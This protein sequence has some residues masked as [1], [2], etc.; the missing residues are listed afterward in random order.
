MLDAFEEQGTV[1][2]VIDN[3]KLPSERL[4]TGISQPTS[5]CL[6]LARTETLRVLS[7]P[8]L[9]G[10]GTRRTSLTS[11]LRNRLAVDNG[12]SSSTLGPAHS[13]SVVDRVEYL[14][15]GLPYRLGII[16]IQHL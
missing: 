9:T 10:D 12:H 11:T 8:T 15:E 6:V 1:F 14:H 13:G 7:S 16:Q 3:T 2:R 5:Q 4:L